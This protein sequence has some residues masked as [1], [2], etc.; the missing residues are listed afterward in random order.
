MP[1]ASGYIAE[2]GQFHPISTESETYD[3]RLSKLASTAY[4]ISSELGFIIDNLGMNL[5][6]SAMQ[7]AF[8]GL[9]YDQTE[10][11]AANWDDYVSELEKERIPIIQSLGELIRQ[12]KTLEKRRDDLLS[13]QRAIGALSTYNIDLEALSVSNT[14]VL[15]LS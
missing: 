4:R 2:I 8:A 15:N 5:N 3:K 11:E 12:R 14:S 7:K 1:E 9:K 10:I 6:P 13:L